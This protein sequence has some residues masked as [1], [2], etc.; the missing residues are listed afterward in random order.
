MSADTILDLASRLLELDKGD[1][2][3]REKSVIERAARRLA[4][5]RNVNVEFQ[6]SATFGQRIAD[7][8]AA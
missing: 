2:T 4:V 3:A 8:V 1:L 6:Q 7:R 5:S